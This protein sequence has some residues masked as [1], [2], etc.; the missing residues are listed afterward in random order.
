MQDTIVIYKSKYGTAAQYAQWIAEDLQCPLLELDQAKKSDIAENTNIIFGGGVH[1][2]GIEGIDKFIKLSKKY[3]K[4][5]FYAAHDSNADYQPDMYKPTK[6]IVFFA[7]GISLGDPQAEKDLRYVNFD[8]KWL[9]QVELYM[10][11][12]RY[13]PAMVKGGDK[14]V[15]GLTLKMLDSQWA[16]MTEAQKL[17]RERIE[18][19][20]DLVDRSQI[21]PIVQRIK[22]GLPTE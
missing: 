20:C 8:K 16:S 4:D 10:L 18:K 11:D 9:R 19:G 12:G 13:D 3:F 14:A 6:R 5:W 15:I 21:A 2:G 22:E 17:L 1:A 7:V